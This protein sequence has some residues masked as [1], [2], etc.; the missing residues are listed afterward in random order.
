MKVIV[1]GGGIAGLSAATR[2]ADDHHEVTLFEKRALLGGRAW[3][4]VDETTGDVIDNGQHV[5]LGCCRALLGFLDR[6]GARA[7]L[8]LQPSLDVTLVDDGQRH[9]IKS[10]PLPAPFHLL[11]GLAGFSAFGLR[12]RLNLL[13]VAAGIAHP[14]A[15]F[16]AASDYETV[17]RWLDRIGQSHG[18]RR[19]FWHPLTRAVL[20]DEPATASAKMLEA[21]L[22]EAFFGGPQDGRL[23]LSRVGLS[24]LYADDAA[25]FVEA[26]GGRV[27]TAAPVEKLLVE[28]RV[29]RGV[30]LRDGSQLVAD[31]VLAAVPPQALY[32]L[33]PAELRHGETFFDG[34]RALKPSP[35]VS[36]HLWFDRLLCHDELLGLVDRPIHW[37]FNRNRFSTVSD[38]QRSHLSCVVSA[39]HELIEASPDQIV[40]L[41][42]DEVRRALP[43]AAHAHLLHSRVLK[44][45]EATIAHTAGSESARPGVRTPIA[46]L[47]AAGDHVRTGLPATLESAVRAADEAVARI[48]DFEPPPRRRASA[49]DLVPAQ[50]LVRRRAEPAE[51]R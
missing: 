41:A 2:L 12:D 3:S 16:P 47:F 29:A 35:I 6:I 40:R 33:V 24:E 36:C 37:I 1:V 18:A 32:D 5:I 46:G 43:G 51:T 19:G 44:E 28:D 20:N 23:G 27:V 13:K 14:T 42:V 30:V 15:L 11:S 4:T 34:L 10:A 31:A 8:Y 49:D 45:R 7:R 21:V 22:R 39:A 48:D 9:R 50:S 38:P 25:R 26:R 17:D